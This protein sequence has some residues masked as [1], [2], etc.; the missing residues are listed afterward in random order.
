M[1]ALGDILGRVAIVCLLLLAAGI[2]RPRSASGG[3]DSLVVAMVA[4][5]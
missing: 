1:S 4:G 3:R 2:A 5:R